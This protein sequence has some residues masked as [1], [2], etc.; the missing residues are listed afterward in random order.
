MYND[1]CVGAYALSLKGAVY[2]LIHKKAYWQYFIGNI[3]DQQ[4]GNVDD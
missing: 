3:H 2:M 4:R 1:M